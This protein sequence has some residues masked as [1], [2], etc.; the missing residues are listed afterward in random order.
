MYILLLGGDPETLEK[1]VDYF[2]LIKCMYILLS[3]ADPEVLE[4]EGGGG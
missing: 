2:E 1:G 4:V 3:E